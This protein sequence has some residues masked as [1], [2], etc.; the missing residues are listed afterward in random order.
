MTELLEWS[1]RIE[2]SL[3]LHSCIH[4]MS[5]IDADEVDYAGHQ[6][7]CTYDRSKVSACGPGVAHEQYHLFGRF[8]P[9]KSPMWNLIGMVEKNIYG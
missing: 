6:F 5:Q 4:Y 7:V 3:P 8:P 2:W 9:K 1:I